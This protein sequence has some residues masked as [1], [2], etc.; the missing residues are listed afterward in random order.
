MPKLLR[1]I[2][3]LYSDTTSSC[4]RSEGDLSGWFPVEAG[5]RQGCVLSPLMFNIFF[6]F[7]IR[8]AV[9]ESIGLQIGNSLVSH[10]E[11][12]DD[13]SLISSSFDEMNRQ[14]RSLAMECARWGLSVSVAK[15]KVLTTERVPQPYQRILLEGAEVERVEGFCH[16]GHWIAADVKC[17]RA[18][19][20]VPCH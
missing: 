19:T 18:L 13:L 7:V 16:L 14:L 8:R 4:V 11:Y 17:R 2:Q 9:D 20:G 15:T 10:L 6:D 1:L 12:A 3:A 5:L